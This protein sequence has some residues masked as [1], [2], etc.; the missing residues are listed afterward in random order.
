MKCDIRK[1]L[2]VLLAGPNGAG[3]TTFYQ[4][5]L[6]AYRLPFINADQIALESFGN[7]APE[8]SIP[9]ARVADELRRQKVAGG[10]SFIFETVLSDPMGDKIDFLRKARQS[11]FFVE[12][13]FIGLA[14]PALSQARVIHRVANGGHDV[15]DDK[16]FSRYQRTLDNLAR[17]L[18]VADRLTIYDN[19]EIAR[20]HRPVALFEEG[21][22]A[23]L[24]SDIPAWLAFLDL[25]AR[26]TPATRSLP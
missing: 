9:A 24:S 10:H 14:S 4:L 8:T 20:P 11:G 21:R 26:V 17:L 23:A 3:K 7:Q 6:A 13:H 2:L 19:S 18:P 12:A 5:H 15:P 22:L 1:P 25:P 16:I